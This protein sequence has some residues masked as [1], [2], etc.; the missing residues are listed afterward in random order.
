[1]IK[2]S[3]RDFLRL[4]LR[5]D[6]CRVRKFDNGII[7]S[8]SIYSTEFLELWDVGDEFLFL[9][10][11]EIFGDSYLLIH[12]TFH[13]MNLDRFDLTINFNLVESNLSILH[14]Q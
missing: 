10:L 13:A 8:R 12:H 4:I 2:L 14:V 7:K 11:K 6:Y 3:S 5:H 1:M 9:K